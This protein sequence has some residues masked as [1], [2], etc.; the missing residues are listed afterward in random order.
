VC[1]QYFGDY[2]RARVPVG[3]LVP[4]KVALQQRLWLKTVLCNRKEATWV[5]QVKTYRIG[6]REFIT[7]C[8][9]LIQPDRQAAGTA[10]DARFPPLTPG[11][12]LLL[13][14]VP[15]CSWLLLSMVLRCSCAA[16]HRHGECHRPLW[17]CWVFCG[18][19][20]WGWCHAEMLC[21]CVLRVLCVCFAGWCAA[22]Q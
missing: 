3:C 20:V 7:Y 10:W 14:M 15:R 11:S 21:L 22:R 18:L 17:L 6:L 2:S 9:V 13:L 16:Q 5:N 8:K 1:I 19:V 4:T 12:W